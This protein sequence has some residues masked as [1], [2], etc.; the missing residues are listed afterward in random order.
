[1][2][3][4]QIVCE[5]GASDQASKPITLPVGRSAMWTATIGHVIGAD[6]CPT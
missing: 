5:F 6:H 1:V 3:G 2:V 4:F